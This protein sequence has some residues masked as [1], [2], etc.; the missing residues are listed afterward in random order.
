MPERWC[1]AERALRNEKAD[2]L[3]A[4]SFERR[5]SLA[6][7]VADPIR[8]LI[9]AGPSR[10]RGDGPRGHPDSVPHAHGPFVDSAS[11]RR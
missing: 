9:V 11:P 8:H 5:Q 6:E 2:F 3:L 10:V 7:Q 4:G 1:A